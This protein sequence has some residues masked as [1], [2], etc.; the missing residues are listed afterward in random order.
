MFF[1]IIYDCLYYI[2]DHLKISFMSINDDFLE[3]YFN[4][5]DDKLR[6]P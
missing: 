4:L 6:G 5:L 3:V 1:C 2:L